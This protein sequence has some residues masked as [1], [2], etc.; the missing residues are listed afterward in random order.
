MTTN[1]ELGRAVL[2]L[3]TDSTSF[4][5]D[6]DAS[7]K[8]T[9]A[10]KGVFASLGKDLKTL[11]AN[12]DSVG[13]ALQKHTDDTKKAQAAHDGLGASI[14][15]TAAG[16]LSAQAIWS[17]GTRLFG[18]LVD[19]AKD[20][21][22]AAGDEEVATAKLR[23]ALIAQGTAA[24]SV[25]AAYR[26]IADQY[27]RTTVF[28]DH[29][30]TSTMGTLAVVGNVMPRDMAK[31]VGAVT[32]LASAFGGAE[33]LEKATLAVSKAAEGNL[34]TLTRLGVVVDAAAYKS[35]GFQAVL[36]AI[37]KKF[38]GQGQALAETYT[39]RIAQLG[40]AWERTEESIGRII[41]QNATVLTAFGD[42][43]RMLQTASTNMTTG[44]TAANFVSDALIG[45]IRAIAGFVSTGGAI[46][47]WGASTYIVLGNVTGALTVLAAGLEEASLGVA[48]LQY[49]A[50]LTLTGGKDIDRLKAN[51]AGLKK[52]YQDLQASEAAA[53]VIRDK[54]RSTADGYAAA[55]RAEADALAKTRGQVVPLTDALGESA[56]AWDRNTKAV[57]AP[58]DKAAAKQ[59][60]ALA[61]LAASSDDLT[62]A[63][64]AE[65]LSYLDLG[66]TAGEIAD[67]LAAKWR[68]SKASIVAYADE[69]KASVEALKGIRSL[70]IAVTAEL[71]TVD[72]SNYDQFLDRYGKKALEAQAQA[73]QWS[74]S[75]TAAIDA[76][77]FAYASKLG[78]EALGHLRT[79]TQKDFEKGI[80]GTAEALN[81]SVG[82]QLQ[83]YQE[84]QN[85]LAL[86]GKR[87][88]DL[89]IA[90]LD[91]EKRAALAH[92]GEWTVANAEW[93]LQ[94]EILIEA[95]FKRRKDLI[96]SDSYVW[97][98]ALQAAGA[99][100][101]HFSGGLGEAGKT[102]DTLGAALVKYSESGKTMGDKLI[103]GFSA[104]AGV[105]GQYAGA[106]IMAGV[107]TGALSGA[108][109][110]AS[111][112]MVAAWGHTA[113]G[114]TALG[115]AS[116]G[117]GAAV[118]AAIALYGA[119]A[120]KHAAEEKANAD[121]TA[122]IKQYQAQLL[123]TLGTLADVDAVGK[124]IGID[125]AGAWG[126]QG[127]AGLVHFSALMDQ[128]TA[129][130]KALVE[131]IKTGAGVASK[132]LLDLMHVY[133]TTSGD[134][135][136]VAID[137]FNAQLQASAEGLTALIGGLQTSAN[138]AAQQAYVETQLAAG[139]TLADA[140]AA[141]K[142]LTGVFLA[143]EAQANGLAAA[144]V[145][146][147]GEMIARGTSFKD[148][149]AAIQGPLTVLKQE[150]AATGYTGGQAFEFLTS[151]S[152]I[153][154]DA[155]MGPLAD[156]IA[157]ANNALKGLHNS[158]VLTQAMFSGIAL[159]ATQAYD[160]IIKQGGDG[161]AALAIMQPE[162]QSVWQLQ[163]DFKFS[164]DA[165]TQALLDQAVASGIVGDGAMTDSQKQIAALDKIADKMGELID[166]FKR[167]FPAAVESGMTQAGAAVD[168]LGSKLTQFGLPIEI[169]Y[170][171]GGTE[172]PRH[173]GP[174]MHHGGL[175]SS[176]HMGASLVAMDETMTKAHGGMLVGARALAAGDVPILAQAG[177]GI[178]SR[179]VG[180]PTLSAWAIK[181]L[182]AG[183]GLSGG[184]QGAEVDV[185]RLAERILTGM[186]T[187][188]LGGDTI[189]NATFTNVQNER[190]L[191]D[192]LIPGIA[193]ELRKGG[194]LQSDFRVAI[195]VER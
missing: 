187:G 175:V 2:D 96:T 114:L 16:F 22:K 20:S 42:L 128:F 172:T 73:Q 65:T 144:V 142:D 156:A 129:K 52:V 170:T 31:A 169:P 121:A 122:Q 79:E 133:E 1:P 3:S 119:L 137:F 184:A 115:A 135:K 131:S 72:A 19:L 76:V 58:G 74:L 192:Q 84:Y 21:I 47:S 27:Q 64:K 105:I 106:S 182:N 62:E 110:G 7:Q 39:G 45:G 132:E 181:A 90:E 146:N 134:S 108:A 167:V 109:A 69:V 70:D 30:L 4:F 57:N 71:P 180:M 178:L 111:L 189:L 149:L 190:Y 112:A 161:A 126:D 29:L 5:A 35:Q 54:S 77:A 174:T 99:E 82:E 85:K 92:L 38:G 13:S 101:S 125:L 26:G 120:A 11:G 91:L 165:G 68:V 163:K 12:V 194:A 63:Q 188:G 51:I 59:A 186:R 46:A 86:M 14:L 40:N 139:R 25:I 195:E 87:G 28:S 33:G 60:A 168:G 138:A 8:A 117:I 159:T 43:S 48:Y 123:T 113:A 173:V 151:M 157:G 143:S 6:L 193:R 153:A 36:D 103:A 78:D 164:V 83:T 183:Q 41:T 37:E 191:R 44:G 18:G 155:V 136:Q 147:F 81:K 148:A 9:T 61:A 17:A 32:D 179:D 100:L 10:L 158:G 80:T 98:N 104:A 130:Q 154:G 93:Y 124:A 171:T 24:P 107:A 185:D 176:T 67:A 162:L 88:I 145:G 102:L 127:T 150:L 66:K 177:E 141:A 56:D 55:L 116:M 118:G 49:G 34:T 166:Y 50:T 75:T 95:Y 15:R 53:A 94:N 23:A 152:T 89:Q 160:Q 97:G 140:Q